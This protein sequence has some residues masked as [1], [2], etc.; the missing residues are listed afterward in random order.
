MQSV[1]HADRPPCGRRLTCSLP[2]DLAICVIHGKI[3]AG[4]FLDG[5]TTIPGDIPFVKVDQLTVDVTGDHGVVTGI[6]RRN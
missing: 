4:A 3:D 2:H 5:I 6:R 1:S